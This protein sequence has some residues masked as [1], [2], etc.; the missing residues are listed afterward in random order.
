MEKRAV[1]QAGGSVNDKGGALRTVRT[2][3][4]WLIP[5]AIGV[6]IAMWLFHQVRFEQQAD[7]VMSPA[8]AVDLGLIRPDQAGHV[9]QIWFVREQDGWFQYRAVYRGLK[10]KEGVIRAGTH[11]DLDKLCAKMSPTDCRLLHPRSAQFEQ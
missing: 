1:L 10:G 5:L 8:V 3:V 6:G 11:V 4:S 2:A 9:G 7:G